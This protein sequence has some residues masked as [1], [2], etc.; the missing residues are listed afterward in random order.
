MEENGL[1]FFYHFPISTHGNFVPD[2]SLYPSLH[3]HVS[4]LV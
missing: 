1:S 2:A 3:S 4:C